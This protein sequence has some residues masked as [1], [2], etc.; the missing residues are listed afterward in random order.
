MVAA[1]FGLIGVVHPLEGIAI[2]LLVGHD[3][4]IVGP[5]GFVE[6]YCGK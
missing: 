1:G 3:L 4:C 2:V 6:S 5:V